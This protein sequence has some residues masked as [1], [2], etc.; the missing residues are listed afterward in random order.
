VQPWPA[1]VLPAVWQERIVVPANVHASP[2]GQP[3][4]GATSLHG[5]SGHPA[6][7]AALDATLADALVTAAMPPAPPE[8]LAPPAE[9]ELAAWLDE[10]ELDVSGAA[11]PVEMNDSPWAHVMHA[12]TSSAPPIVPAQRAC[13]A[14]PRSSL[15]RSVRAPPETGQRFAWA[16]RSRV[17]TTRIR[18][19]PA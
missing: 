9:P 12:K 4:C 14:A 16:A 11:P 8:P 10:A 7:D 17:K 5:D 13:I 1:G 3:H 15:Q 2:G 18:P 6:L 19:G